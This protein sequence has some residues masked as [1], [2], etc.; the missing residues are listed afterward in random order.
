MARRRHSQNQ[1]DEASVDLTPML[2]IV[3]IMLIF[4]IVTAVFIREPG[5][6]VIRPDTETDVRQNRIAILI[7]VNEDNE[8]WIDNREIEPNA[9]RAVVERMRSENPQGAIVLQ[10]DVDSDSGVVVDII[11]QARL[12]GAPSVAIATL[13]DD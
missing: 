3:F 11:D 13:N 7:A 5:I 1:N 8:I 10:A 4:F 12:A 2:D 6:D 9:V